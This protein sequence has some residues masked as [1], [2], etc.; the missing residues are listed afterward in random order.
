MELSD[1]LDF[2]RERTHGVLVTAK[3]DGRPQLSNVAYALG[4]DGV[5]RISVTDERAKTANVR[6][7]PRVS[8]HVTR[9][10]FYAY[11]VFEGDAELTPVASSPGDGTV[12]ELADQYRVIA[13]EHPD[14]HEFRTAMV[15]DNRLIVR[16]HPERAYGML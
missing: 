16:L 3:R 8:L 11:A 15:D 12:D 6:R 2:A 1:A 10:D 7:D 9:D 13:G 14:W 5:F 4:D